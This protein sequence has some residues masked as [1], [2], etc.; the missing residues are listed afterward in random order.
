MKKIATIFIIIIAT[1]FSCK[2][3]RNEPDYIA[4]NDTLK[5]ID[6]AYESNSIWAKYNYDQRRGKRLFEHYCSVCHGL[7]GEGDGFNS[8]NLISK[9]HS[10]ADSV[11]MK[12]LTKETL[13]QI[14]SFGGVSNNKSNE[15]PAY[16]YTLNKYQIDY[17]ISYI[18]TL[19]Q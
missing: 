7:K 14:I 12:N 2:E 16:S 19:M 17:L 13:N 5:V 6:Q 3:E 4:Y 10:L 1:G 15:M 11:Y 9:P 18:N 8:Y